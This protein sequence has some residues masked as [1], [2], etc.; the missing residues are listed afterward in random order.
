[1]VR[2][3]R[4][5]T[6]N[7]SLEAQQ[8]EVKARLKEALTRVFEAQQALQQ[9]LSDEHLLS[10]NQRKTTALSTLDTI[11]K[12]PRKSNEETSVGGS[13]LVSGLEQGSE[14]EDALAD[15]ED[16]ELEVA[17][18]D[19]Q[20]ELPPSLP[21][22]DIHEEQ[23]T[24]E[25]SMGQLE[26]QPAASCVVM[27]DPIHFSSESDYEQ[28]TKLRSDEA[29]YNGSW[30]RYALRT[31]KEAHKLRSKTR[32][33]VGQPFVTKF[34]ASAVCKEAKAQEFTQL[35]FSRDPASDGEDFVW[36]R[37]ALQHLKKERK[38]RVGFRDRAESFSSTISIV[39]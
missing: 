21:S 19:N 1:M 18:S 30:Y 37:K 10:L 8:V 20:E 6:I 38:H 24:F 5:E 35:V 22:E 27:C 31:L 32:A 26:L 33:T 25:L 23:E 7:A 13:N 4:L 12:A 17:T 29:T 15:Y 9:K 2:C 39:D 36:Y 14:G 28:L 3:D 16:I 34:T 11:S